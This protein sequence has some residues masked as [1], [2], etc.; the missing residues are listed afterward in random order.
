MRLKHYL[1]FNGD[2]RQAMT[3]YAGL[4]G[5]ELV[6]MQS[7]GDTPGCEGMPDEVRQ[8][9]LHGRVDLGPF[10]LMGTDAIP[11]HPYEGVNGAYVVAD[12]DEPEQAETLYAAL[13][14]GAPAIEMPLQQTFWARRYGNLTDRF[15]VRWMINCT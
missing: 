2:C 7:Y 11:D 13:S 9:I 12:V 3:F 4:L 5:G 6:A 1:S 8:R 15:G 10:S 14:E